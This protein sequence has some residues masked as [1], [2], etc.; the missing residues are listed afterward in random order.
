MKKQEIRLQL[1]SRGFKTDD[2]DV[3]L[4][5]ADTK[6][7]LMMA[8]AVKY[9]SVEYIDGLLEASIHFLR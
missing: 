6:L 9:K 8:N 5:H 4:A 1:I 3:F 2:I 7:L